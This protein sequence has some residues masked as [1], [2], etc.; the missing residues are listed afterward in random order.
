MPVVLVS[1]QS[2]EEIACSQRARIGADTGEEAIGTRDFTR[3]Q[4]R[5]FG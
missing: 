1:A 5:C 2:D 4:M 3:E